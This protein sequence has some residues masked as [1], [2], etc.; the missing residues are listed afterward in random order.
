MTGLSV[1]ATSPPGDVGHTGQCL[2]SSG[3]ANSKP[4][5]PGTC[6]ARRAGRSSGADRPANAPRRLLKPPTYSIASPI[7]DRFALKGVYYQPGVDTTLRYDSTTGVPGTE[8]SAED[9]F[10]AWMTN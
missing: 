6:G 2:G 7:T 1:P 3:H 4:I 8:F 10:Q 5:Q 9:T